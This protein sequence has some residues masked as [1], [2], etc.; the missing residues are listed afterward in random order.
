MSVLK[1]LIAV[2]AMHGAPTLMGV[3]PAIATPDTQAVGFLAQVSKSI[4][5]W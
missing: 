4:F 5:K 2:I 3:T 1:A